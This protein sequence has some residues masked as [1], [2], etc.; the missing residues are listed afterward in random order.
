[1]SEH[2]CFCC[3]KILQADTTDNPM[4]ISPIYDG[5]WFRTT[6]NYG[7]TVFDPMPIGTEEILQII[8]CDDCIGERVE[9]VTR[10]H[11]LERTVTA[12]AEPFHLPVPFH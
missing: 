5:L 10:I 12:D 9:R 7:S 4:V 2:Q 1:M 6:G 8:I 11:N 3:G